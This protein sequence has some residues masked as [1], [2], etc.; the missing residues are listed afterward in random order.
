MCKRVCKGSDDGGDNATHNTTYNPTF[1]QK[2]A[3]LHFMRNT[4]CNRNGNTI[5]TYTKFDSSQNLCNT[6]C[7][8]QLEY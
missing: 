2:F 6:V 3:Q 4:V 7:K 5:Q 1:A 8:V